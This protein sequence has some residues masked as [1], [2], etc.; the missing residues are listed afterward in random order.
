M[1]LKTYYKKQPFLI[2][3]PYNFLFFLDTLLH[4]PKISEKTNSKLVM[5]FQFFQEKF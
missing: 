3:A 2:F 1:K 4:E 5:V